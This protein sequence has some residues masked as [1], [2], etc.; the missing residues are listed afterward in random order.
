[1][2]DPP[3]P[4]SDIDAVKLV[5]ALNAEIF[6]TASLL[7]ESFGTIKSR[8][9]EGIDNR[10]ACG[11][12]HQMF[13]PRLVELLRTIPHDENPVLLRVAFQACMVVFSDW[14]SAAWH[15][16]MDPA[17]QFFGEVYRNVWI[18]EDQAVSGR[19]RSLTRQ[20]IQQLLNETPEN[21][22]SRFAVHI[23]DSLADVLLCA[24]LH[25]KHSQV[26]EAVIA[27]ASEKIINVVDIALRLNHMLGED[28]TSADIETTWVHS[29]EPF[30]SMWME[31]DYGDWRGNGHGAVRVLCTTDLGLRRLVKAKNDNGWEDKVLVK[32]KVALEE[33][34]DSPE[35]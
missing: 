5:S 1:M 18:A 35:S 26:G 22:K 4:V 13:G 12:V 30:D 14:I 24:G 34:T 21:I 11:R 9:L 32:P 10:S 17:P 16:Q 8:A 33:V 15:F 28:I 7:A 2:F 31:D 23:A 29:Q 25:N 3:D 27:M 20:H 19:W 6:Q